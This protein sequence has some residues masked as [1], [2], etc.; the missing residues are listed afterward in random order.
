MIWKYDSLL[1]LYCK[2][3]PLAGSGVSAATKLIHAATQ[4]KRGLGRFVLTVHKAVAARKQLSAQLLALPSGSQP[5]SCLYGGWCLSAG[6]EREQSKCC[7]GFSP[8]RNARGCQGLGSFPASLP[9][10][11]LCSLQ[12]H[13]AAL[14]RPCAGMSLQREASLDSSL[15]SGGSLSSLTTC[16]S[17]AS[18]SLP[19]LLLHRATVG[20]RYVPTICHRLLPASFAVVVSVEKQFQAC[21]S[22]T[23]NNYMAFLH[24]Q[25]DLSPI[26]FWPTSQSN[27]DCLPCGSVPVVS[28]LQDDLKSVNDF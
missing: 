24:H 23:K 12:R 22:G 8:F 13:A 4:V 17:I 14:P 15:C 25:Y 20:V 27:S 6:S 2:T 11:L 19:W 16:T 1:W 7:F 5:L 21:F 10:G 26:L 28:L 3:K 18:F 9:L